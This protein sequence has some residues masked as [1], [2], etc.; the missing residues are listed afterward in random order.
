MFIRFRLASLISVTI[1]I[2]K[3]ERKEDEIGFYYF[4]VREL[5]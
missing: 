1:T 3:E 5:H 2:V 4:G